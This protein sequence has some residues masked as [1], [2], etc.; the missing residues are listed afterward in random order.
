MATISKTK[1]STQSGFILPLVVVVVIIVALIGAG[2]VSLGYHSRI[3]S[4]R[5][6]QH[7][8][9]VQ[10]AEA[11]ITQAL[12]DM[13]YTKIKYDGIPED[14]LGKPELQQ[15]TDIYLPS[16]G[17]AKF[18]YIIEE[19]TDTLDPSLRYK[20]TSTGEAPPAKKVFVATTKLYSILDFAI[21]VKKSIYL[22]PNSIVNAIDS[23]AG[24]EILPAQIATNSTDESAVIAKPGSVVNGDVLVGAGGDP[25]YIVD[26]SGGKGSITGSLTTLSQVYYFP[27]VYPPPL[28]ALLAGKTTKITG[29][30]IDCTQN[31]V[32]NS[33]DLPKNGTLEFVKKPSVAD[34]YI[35]IVIKGDLNMGI[36]S[37]INANPNANVLIKVRGNMNMDGKSTLNAKAL[38]S[39]VIN[40]MGNITMKSDS[41]IT[42]VP[43]NGTKLAIYLYG[44]W[45]SQPNAYINNAGFAGNLQIYGYNPVWQ[46]ITLYSNNNFHGIIYAPTADLNIYPRDSITGSFMSNNFDLKS[47]GV[48]TYDYSS[49]NISSD[50]LK[51]FGISRWLR[52]Q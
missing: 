16:A 49:K 51:Y 6:T 17:G 22:Y 30:S 25:D 10:A 42:V 33:I 28:P 3:L 34:P 50:A 12:R 45:V 40:V 15:N 36:S 4:H 13:N 35:I 52:E 2:I 27:L 37:V 46:Q 43:G 7:I 44:N 38:A 48:V 1:N 20:I 29:G 32:Y 39:V 24:N 26:D 19:I 31:G 11:G 41:G 9:A 5:N 23:S 47:K 14:F 21:F 18:N 8:L